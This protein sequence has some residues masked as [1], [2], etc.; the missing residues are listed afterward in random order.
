MG[1]FTYFENTQ[2]ELDETKRLIDYSFNNREINELSSEDFWF[3]Y[4]IW[5][6]LLNVSVEQIDSINQFI[7]NLIFRKDE[8]HTDLES[9]IHELENKNP[10]NQLIRSDFERFRH[11]NFDVVSYPKIPSGFYGIENSFE[12]IEN[13]I[14]WSDKKYYELINILSLDTFPS[15]SNLRLVD[16]FVLV[17]IIICE[18][19]NF[20]YLQ[21]M[22]EI[23][24]CLAFLKG[25]P[26]PANY[27][28]ILSVEIINRWANFLILPNVLASCDSSIKNEN[29]NI[30]E[31]CTK[32]NEL[33][34]VEEKDTIAGFLHDYFISDKLEIVDKFYHEDISKDFKVAPSLYRSNEYN[35]IDSI[36]YIRSKIAMP[37]QRNPETEIHAIEQILNICSE[38]HAFGRFHIPKIFNEIERNIGANTWCCSIFITCG[39]SLFIEIKNVLLFWLNLIFSSSDIDYTPPYFPKIQT[40][41]QISTFLIV[42]LKSLENQLKSDIYFLCT[43]KFK[44]DL[45]LNLRAGIVS[46]LNPFLLTEKNQTIKENS[47]LSSQSSLFEEFIGDEKKS[48][49]LD[50]FQVILAMESLLFSTPTSL[51]SK[52]LFSMDFLNPFMCSGSNS[53]TNA[54]INFIDPRELLYYDSDFSIKNKKCLNGMVNN[55]SGKDIILIDIL[56]SYY[57][58]HLM[59]SDIERLIKRMESVEEFIK[60]NEF[61]ARTV[62]EF[63]SLFDE[64]TSSLMLLPLL[65]LC[66]K[67]TRIVKI[68]LEKDGKFIS[69]QA[70][71]QFLEFA[72]RRQHALLIQQR[73]C[74]WIVSGPRNKI[75]NEFSSKLIANGL[76]GVQLIDTDQLFKELIYRYYSSNLDFLTI[77]KDVKSHLCLDI[78][79]PNYKSR[80][81]LKIST[82]KKTSVNESLILNKIEQEKNMGSSNK[83]EPKLNHEK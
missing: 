26:V 29:S 15:I 66:F 23:V 41:L 50:L 21:G 63:Y 81:L 77:I 46:I 62:Y 1:V 54:P 2:L 32:E 60:L 68:P 18:Y 22:H 13:N 64:E 5:C 69:N 55:I 48:L 42:L 35:K 56:S 38:F 40:P 79:R 52:M 57:T 9:I 76:I 17:T 19:L 59:D 75:R 67:T 78:K 58:D 49:F 73:P 20:N 43:D 31:D 45:D 10:C 82:L 7:T 34:H 51:Q 6:I 16:R 74:I 33:M 70:I 61:R 80:A 53:C 14:N 4:R 47:Y 71:S 30:L 3:D 28:I 24:G 39:S 12:L 44:L 36:Q 37:L 65:R 72:L 11:N 8:D 83:K 27:H 25:I